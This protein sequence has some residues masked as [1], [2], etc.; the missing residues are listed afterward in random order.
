MFI[1]L[2]LHG[3]L[4]DESRDGWIGKVVHLRGQEG[5]VW[6]GSPGDLPVLTPVS[7]RSGSVSG[8]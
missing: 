4:F 2:L 5:W 8:E 7:H 6:L 3:R 1:S